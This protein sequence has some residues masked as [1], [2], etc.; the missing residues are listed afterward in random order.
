MGLGMTNKSNRVLI[1]LHGTLALALPLLVALLFGCLKVPKAGLPE[2]GP[3]ATEDELERVISKA[4]YGINPCRSADGQQVIYDFNARIENQ[5]Q[6]RPLARLYQTTLSRE[7]EPKLKLVI[8]SD[9][10]DLQ[11]GEWKEKSEEIMEFDVQCGASITSKGLDK[12]EFA[13]KNEGDDKG[14][15]VTETTYHNL[16]ESQG[17]MDPPA[18]VMAK[19]NCG[20][21]PNCKLRYFRLEYDEVKWFSK[22]EY[23]VQRWLFT[24]SRDAPFLGHIQERCLAGMINSGGGRFYVVRQCQFARDFT[25]SGAQ[26]PQY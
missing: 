18:A 24:I 15:E 11:D 7:I 20:D 12:S 25:Y 13:M 23:E 10:L 2:L 1:V 9:E 19:P 16:K 8:G 5:E 6:V 26:R 22:D 4:L 14:R 17:T 21:V 3:Q